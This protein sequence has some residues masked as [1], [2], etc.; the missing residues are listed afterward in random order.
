M[1]GAGSGF[2]LVGGA[3]PDHDVMARAARAVDD[4]DG[5]LLAAA[6]LLGAALAPCSVPC[7]VH[8]P[9]PGG[10]APAG[11][12]WRSAT[13]A[14]GS[15]PSGLSPKMAKPAKA[16]RNRPSKTASACSPVNGSR[17]RRLRRLVVCPSGALRSSA[18]SAMNY[19]EST[20]SDDTTARQGGGRAAI[21]RR[22]GGDPSS[23]RWARG[24]PDRDPPQ[25][26]GGPPGRPWKSI[27]R[28]EPV[29]SRPCRPACPRRTGSG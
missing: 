7:S 6:G 1:A 11:A 15:P 16:A 3:V 13:W 2:G 9:A 26:R 17:K 24:A 22:C 14:I 20:E 23:P 12:V 10:L 28:L 19:P 4:G 25:K 21:G 8:G 27:Y 29:S 18:V 5:L